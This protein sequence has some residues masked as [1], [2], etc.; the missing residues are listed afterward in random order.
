MISIFNVEK[1][2]NSTDKNKKVDHSE[3]PKSDVPPFSLKQ[4]VQNF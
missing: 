1:Y 4:M 2:I 3:G